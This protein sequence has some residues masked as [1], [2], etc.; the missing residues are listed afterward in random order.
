MLTNAIVNAT[1]FKPLSA[2]SPVF[3]EDSSGNCTGSS[4]IDPA[5]IDVDYTALEDSMM[6]TSL[7][8]AASALFFFTSA[9]YV[10]TC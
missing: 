1:A 7:F 2:D 3:L 6:I 9:W 4:S 5:T 10:L 8:E